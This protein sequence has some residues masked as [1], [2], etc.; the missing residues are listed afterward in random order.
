MGGVAGVEDRVHVADGFDRFEDRVVARG[1]AVVVHPLSAE[2]KAA[3]LEAASKIG[4]PNELKHLRA[5]LAPLIK[6]GLATH[7]WNHRLSKRLPKFLYFDEYYQMEGQVNID[8][9]RQRQAQNALLPSDHPMLGL[10]GLAD[11]E[12][13]QILNSQ[14]TQ[15]LNNQL[16]GAGNYLS[17]QILKYWS[18]NK[19]ISLWVRV[20][21]RSRGFIRLERHR[22]RPTERRHTEPSAISPIGSRSMR[23]LRPSRL[24][25][26][27]AGRVL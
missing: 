10:I 11:L 14:N 16:E 21:T 8:T 23:K 2:E 24:V 3:A 13:D 6:E 4:E 9:L 5:K 25:A 26:R 18:Q 7:I 17:R 20:G 22:T 1:E 19:H 12:L 15:D 27:V